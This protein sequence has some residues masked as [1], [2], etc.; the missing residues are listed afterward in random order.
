MTEMFGDV[1]IFERLSMVGSHD[2]FHFQLDKL[3]IFNGLCDIYLITRYKTAPAATELENPATEARASVAIV[4][5]TT[6][7]VQ[8][9]TLFH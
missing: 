6:L 8:N 2:L 1:S 5:A 4:V 3:H 7:N 9:T